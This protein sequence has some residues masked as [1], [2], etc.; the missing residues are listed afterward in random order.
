MGKHMLAKQAHLIQVAEATQQKLDEAH[1]KERAHSEVTH[2][3]VNSFVL[4]EYPD[5]GFRAGSPTKPLTYL[6]GP[7]CE[8]S[9]PPEE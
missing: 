6:K 4:I 9:I 3:P 1:I 8:Y 2:F 7:L 5:T